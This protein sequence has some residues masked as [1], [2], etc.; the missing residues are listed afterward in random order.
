MHIAFIFFNDYNK[1]NS[2]QENLQQWFSMTDWSTA[3]RK[4]GLEVSIF[5]RSSYDE[6]FMVNGGRYYAFSDNL[7]AKLSNW[8]LPFRYLN[9]ITKTFKII[10][11]SIIHAHNLNSIIHNLI[12]RMI[13]PSQIPMVIQDHASLPIPK[14]AVFYR[15]LFKK[16]DALL[17]SA[18]G[19]EMEWLKGNYIVN[20]DKIEYIMENSTS[21]KFTDRQ[22][23]RTQTQFYGDPVFLWV[24]NLTVNKDPLTILSAFKAVIAKFPNPILYMFYR[25]EDLEEEVKAFIQDHPLLSKRVKLQG[26]LPRRSMQSVYNSA[27]YFLLGSYKEGSGYALMEAMACGVIPIVTNIPSFRRLLGNGKVGKLWPPGQ[28]SALIECIQDLSKSSIQEESQKVL[29]H[30]NQFFSFEAL[31]NQAVD[32]YGEIM[33]NLKS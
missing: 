28:T 2:P 9:K 31:G 21:F 8:H 25:E 24:G 6:Q 16:V 17:F 33:A 4:K 30:F 7:P 15:T 27:D 20:P 1:K 12:L 22:I 5:F 10:N 26:Y 13:T 18:P 19:Q 14:Y 32:I 29:A 11:P 23:A 3:L